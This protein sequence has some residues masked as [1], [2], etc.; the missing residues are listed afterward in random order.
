[1]LKPQIQIFS[2]NNILKG[3]SQ[4]WQLLWVAALYTDSDFSHLL[5]IIIWRVARQ[6]IST[7][8]KRELT[9]Y[10]QHIITSSNNGTF[11]LQDDLPR[12]VRKGLLWQQKD[13]FFSRWKERFFVLT[14]DYLQCFK[15][16]NSRITE[17][18]SFLA[19]VVN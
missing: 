3:S 10:L 13:K 7:R 4:L 1:M 11:Q 17:M 12:P 19:R 15:K 14:D 6:N 2:E 16:E 18:G 9:F 8:V 5:F